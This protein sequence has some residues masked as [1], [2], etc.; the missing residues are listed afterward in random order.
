LVGLACQDLLDELNQEGQAEIVKSIYANCLSFYDI[1]AKEIRQRL[2]VKEEF[3]NKLRNPKLLC[4]KTKRK[5]LKMFFSLPNDLA[6]L[7]CCKKN[8]NY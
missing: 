4:K 5:K 1:A 2:F 6:A 3:L 7:R 8:G